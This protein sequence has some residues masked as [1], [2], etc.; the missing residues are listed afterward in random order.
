VDEKSFAYA[1]R[2]VELN[3]LQERVRVVKV[4]QGGSLF[5]ID[6]GILVDLDFAMCNPP[7]YA[8]KD[9][10]LASAAAKSRPPNSACTGAEIEMVAPGGEVGFVDRMIRDSYDS[11]HPIQWYTTMLGKLSSV[12][13]VVKMV[14]SH[15]VNNFAVKEFVQ[16]G[17]TKRWGVAWSWRPRRPRMVCP[18]TWMAEHQL[19]E[20]GQ[21][22]LPG[23]PPACQ[24]T[25]FPPRQRRPFQFRVIR[26]TLPSAW[27]TS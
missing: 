9:E 5:Q 23:E 21:R 24:S 13:E 11:G 17:R 18:Q 16:G 10:L 8:S 4:E 7:F 2:N 19:A 6:R 3:S 25:S 26:A 12:A 27:R 14:R 1:K 15:G 22:M 20:H